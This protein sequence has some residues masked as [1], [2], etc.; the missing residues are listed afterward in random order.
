M[1]EPRKFAVALLAFTLVTSAAAGAEGRSK[2]DAIRKLLEIAGTAALMEQVSNQML[3]VTMQQYWKL[4]KQLHPQAPDRLRPLM[5]EELSRAFSESIPEFIDLAIA[6]YSKH[7]TITE[8]NEWIAFYESELGRKIARVTPEITAETMALGE[9]WGRHIVGPLARE[10][11]KE[12][13]RQEGY[14]L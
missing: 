6:V 4:I 13:L 5:E 11:V 1:M 2:D 8:V 10:R 3:Q 7:F 12:K 9:Q 14:D